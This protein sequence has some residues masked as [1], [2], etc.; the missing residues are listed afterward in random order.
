MGAG[1]NELTTNLGGYYFYYTTAPTHLKL[2]SFYYYY[3][4]CHQSSSLFHAPDAIMNVFNPRLFLSSFQ[5][6]H[7]VVVSCYLT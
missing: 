4:T 2:R 6:D 7:R 1:W 5:L 3:Q